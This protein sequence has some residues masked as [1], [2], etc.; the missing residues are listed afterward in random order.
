MK[1]SLFEQRLKELGVQLLPPAVKGPRMGERRAV[2]PRERVCGKRVRRD[3]STADDIRQH[4]RLGK[5]F[6]YSQTHI[7]MRCAACNIKRRIDYA[8]DGSVK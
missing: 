4:C 7:M 5:N 1:Q 8:P 3:N 6:Y 2:F